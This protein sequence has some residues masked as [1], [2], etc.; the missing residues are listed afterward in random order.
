[1]RKSGFLLIL[2][3]VFA[4]QTGEAAFFSRFAH[5]APHS[6][7]MKTE[8]K[9]SPEEDYGP[10][11]RRG[12]VR[13]GT[14]KEL[15]HQNIKNLEDSI[16]DAEGI[17][18][19]IKRFV[20]REEAELNPVVHDVK[21]RVG[22]FG[23]YIVNDIDEALTA[24]KTDFE[25]YEKTQD[26]Q[27]KIDDIENAVA[28][29]KRKF[30]KTFFIQNLTQY[31]QGGVRRRAADQEE[32]EEED[33]AS[34]NPSNIASDNPSN[35]ASDNPLNTTNQNKEQSPPPP[36]ASTKVSISVHKLTEAEIKE[37][38]EEKEKARLAKIEEEKKKIQEEKDKEK[39]S[40]EKER[41]KE[42]KMKE[43]AQKQEDSIKKYFDGVEK[44]PEGTEKTPEELEDFAVKLVE[45][46]LEPWKVAKTPEQI[47]KIKDQIKEKEKKRSGMSDPIRGGLIMRDINDLKTELDSIRPFGS[48]IN[49]HLQEFFQ[50]TDSSISFLIQKEKEI[51]EKGKNIKSLKYDQAIEK[52][53]KLVNQLKQDFKTQ[54]DSFVDF[55]LIKKTIKDLNEKIEAKQAQKQALETAEKFDDLNKKKVDLSRKIVEKEEGKKRLAASKDR[56]EKELAEFSEG[57]SRSRDKIQKDLE[58]S[59]QNLIVAESDI[60][61][62]NTKKTALK[63]EEDTLN[64]KASEMLKYTRE[65]LEALKTKHSDNMKLLEKP[66]ED[67]RKNK[68]KITETQ[69]ELKDTLEKALD[70]VNNPV[71]FS[72]EITPKEGKKIKTF[73]PILGWSVTKT[74][75]EYTA[76]FSKGQKDAEESTKTAEE[77]FKKAQEQKRAEHESAQK[78]SEEVLLTVQ[79][80]QP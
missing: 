48:N 65:A 2:Y 10:I 38:E 71:E 74:I 46:R 36:P 18:P 75:E 80:T 27:D 42:K 61:E 29:I 77:S 3:V 23:Q 51:K 60:A 45:E 50:P 20:Y 6:V 35:I 37:I 69:K 7:A 44:T 40:E 12:G 32:E 70:E 39:E 52:Y 28:D 22:Q 16:K 30:D 8:N 59:K 19:E 43:T 68:E 4:E 13:A 62:L 21:R 53:Y 17:L 31:T 34:D 5:R 41:E 47:N 56:F 9:T 78:V 49:A 63:D 11:K 24:L 73:K 14:V 64:S 25:H 66:T 55:L 54:V 1:M 79:K 26:S 76:Q 33:T 72:V 58:N 15:F 57:E 67:G